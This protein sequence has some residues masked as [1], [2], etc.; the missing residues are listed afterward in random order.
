MYDA[1]KKVTMPEEA[2]CVL[3]DSNGS[4]CSL[5]GTAGNFMHNDEGLKS[6]AVLP[7]KEGAGNN[8]AA[9]LELSFYTT[10]YFQDASRNLLREISYASQRTAG[11]N[12]VGTDKDARSSESVRLLLKSLLQNNWPGEEHRRMPL[13]INILGHDKLDSQN[14]SPIRL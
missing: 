7:T 12:G 11:V 14:Q 8:S 3:C 5:S 10:K 4:L 13:L 9:S 2:N 6:C 1:I